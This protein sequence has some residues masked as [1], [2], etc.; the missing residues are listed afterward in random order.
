MS[1]ISAT[2]AGSPA[3]D[4]P[5]N[6][7]KKRLI[8]CCDGTWMN[9]DT[10][11]EK[12]TLFNPI[13]K[14]QTPSNVTRLSR[15]LRRVC[16]DGTLQIIAYQ[17]GVGTG[18][19]M[20]DAITGGAFGRGIAENVREAYAFICANYNDG[21]DIILV[22]FSR[23]AFTA[24][25]VAGMIGDLGLL[26]RAGMDDFYP[27]FKDMQ[28]WRTPDYRDPFPNVPFP[29]K[30]KGEGAEDIYRQLLLDRGLTRVNQNCGTG[31]LIKVK[32]VGVWDTVG[33]L[34]IPQI[35]WLP[36]LSIGAASKEYRFYDT[37]LSDRIEHAFQ[38][39]ALDE[40]RPP[41]SPAVWERSSDNKH[42]TELR[43]VWFPGNHG[44]VGGGWQDAGIANMS[45]AWM[46]DQ[47]ASVG[48]EFD[49][50]TIARLAT[51]VAEAQAASK[52][53]RLKP[54]AIHQIY[55][56]NHPIRPWGQGALLKASGLLYALAGFTLRTPGLYRKISL[57]TGLPSPTFLEDTNER[58]HSS[59]RVRL[60]TGG[61]GLNDGEVWRAPALKG[62]WRPRRTSRTYVDP[63]P[64]TRKTWEQVREQRPLSLGD[65]GDGDG[66]WVWEYCGPEGEAPEV[67]VLVEEPLGPYERQ[68]LRLASG[69][70]NIYE[71]ADGVDVAL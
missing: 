66:R 30:P 60:A 5:L 46:M 51:A 13:G 32:A 17:N 62:K 11:Y 14:A 48:V 49:E 55:E 33:S 20:A 16:R 40:H 39:L 7:P 54:W 12:P 38:A 65:G 3:G 67:R 69:K 71:F 56:T 52:Q 53:N 21:D 26:T 23:G 25:S 19:T 29:N 68:L 45:L 59:V 22:G 50:A 8:V 24:R 31:D 1:S 27:I 64:K 42:T 61:L 37:N 35:S 63:I 9:S 43:Q 44:N 18:S 58:I 15:S 36:K 34:G 28:N 41:F 70:P 47:L 4:L 10:G 6:V 57:E 2:T